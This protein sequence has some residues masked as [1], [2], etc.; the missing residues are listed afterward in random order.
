MSQVLIV[1][2][3]PVIRSALVHMLTEEK[4]GISA[5]WEA[6]NGEEAVQLARDHK[7]DIILMDIK[8]PGLTGLQATAVIRR[9]QPDVKIIMLTAYNEFSYVQKALKLGAR[10][11]LLKPVRPNKLLE[12]LAEIHQEIEQERRDLRTVEIVKDSLQKTMPVIEA[13][14]VENLIRG[15]QPEG[16]STEESLAYLG[17]RL[18]WPA[19]LVTKI[20]SFDTVSERQSATTLQQF[21][22]S[23]V[24]IIRRELPVPQH[25]LV[26]YSYPGRVVAIVS[27]EMHL[28]TSEQ[29]RG[30]GER[31]CTAV[32]TTLPFT[33]TIGLGKRYMA[34]E[35]IPL[36]YAEANLA[37]RLLS[38]LPGNVVV[39][40][41]DLEYLP[42]KGDPGL[43]IVQQERELVQMVQANQ[44]QNAQKLVN[45]IL[46]YLSQRYS[47]SPEAM[48]NHCAELVTLLAWGVVGA[49]VN[50]PKVLNVLQQQVRALA[51]W[52]TIPEIRAWTLNSLAEMMTFMQEKS[53]RPDAVQQALAYLHQ[54]YQRPDISLQELAE[55]VNLSQSHLSSQFKTAVGVSYVKHLTSIRLSEAQK[56]LRT[57]DQS[58]ATIAETVGYPNVT[59]FYRH[60]QRH[61]GTTPAAYRES[62]T[63]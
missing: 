32:A 24:K 26:G 43:Y 58:V 28:A 48:K 41:E 1:D 57:T 20:D 22:T 54:N 63:S 17:K 14:L 30:L 34:L 56:L 62:A 31:I 59:N 13:S 25:A 49:G 7:P 2:D 37:R 27:T 44:P 19:V 39:G 5:V 45:H 15:T 29:L 6:S 46:D 50:N 10:D 52:K 18:V 60:F 11:Y 23:L 35:S 38:H 42:A 47:A 16:T 36:S 9:E 12:L 21:I 40:I 3:M 61:F 33:V 4:S 55:A 51:S 8:M 53:Q